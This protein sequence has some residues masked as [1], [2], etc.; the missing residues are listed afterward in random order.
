MRQLTNLE[1]RA[2]CAPG[3]LEAK[4]K[5][6]HALLGAKV[7]LL[8]APEGLYFP[9]CSDFEDPCLWA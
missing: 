8:Q 6:R 9:T 5:L 7:C 3:N 4:S 2:A 1:E